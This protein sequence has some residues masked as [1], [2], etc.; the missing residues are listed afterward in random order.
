MRSE[1]RRY[2]T[3][4]AVSQLADYEL[5]ERLLRRLSG[6]N[7]IFDVS[8]GDRRL[9]PQLQALNTLAPGSPAVKAR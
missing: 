7:S 9:T 8:G 5:D 4:E 3:P 2:P 1:Y 6:A